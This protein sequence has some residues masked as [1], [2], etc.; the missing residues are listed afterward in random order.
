[1]ADLIRFLDGGAIEGLAEESGVTAREIVANLPTQARCF[2]SAKKFMQVMDDIAGWG[3]VSVVLRTGDGVVEFIS[4][5]PKGDVAHGYF[6]LLGE[7]RIRAHLRYENCAAVAFVERPFMGRPSA[8]VLF[9]DREGK[10][11]FKICVARDADG[12]LHDDQLK[13]FRAL[14]ARLTPSTGG[15]TRTRRKK[16]D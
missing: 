5:L 1:M 3:E 11:M 10:I 14:A 2:V 13:S 9:F 12:A 4:T 6:R 7:G 8:A 15:K 16:H